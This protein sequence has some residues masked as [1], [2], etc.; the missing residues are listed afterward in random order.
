MAHPLEPFEKDKRP[1][2]RLCCQTDRGTPMPVGH[3]RT[4]SVSLLI[5]ATA[6][7]FL[8]APGG[9]LQAQSVSQGTLIPPVEA[10]FVQQGDFAAAL[11]FRLGLTD[12]R[13]RGEAEDR[14]ASLGIKPV[15]GW[16]SNDPVTPDILG[17]LEAAIGYAAD[18]NLL[19]L[20]PD[21]ALRTFVQ[22]VEESGMGITP[23]A[24]A[25]GYASNGAI[26]YPDQPYFTDYYVTEGPPII[27][28]YAPPPAYYYL[29][30]WV[31]YPFW[32]GATAFAGYYILKDRH[33]HSHHGGHASNRRYYG[34]GR[35]YQYQ[36]NPGRNVIG[37]REGYQGGRT[38]GRGPWTQ[39]VPRSMISRPGSSQESRISTSF[40]TAPPR[41]PQQSGRP[42]RQGKGGD[43]SRAPAVR[44]STGAET[45]LFS[46]GTVHLSPSAPG[47]VGIRQGIST[48]GGFRQPA[49][50][51]WSRGVGGPGF[52]GSG[53]AGFRR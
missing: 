37:P 27:T 19:P 31:P 9:L 28:Y 51:G 4:R 29:Y 47:S 36:A 48:G 16:V 24:G 15:G 30:S 17:Q 44:L 5:M 43:F 49:A 46:P 6:L 41:V 23:G 42:E 1:P 10:Q 3:P 14:L 21:E 25:A 53:H 52:S 38:G 50:R 7:I 35:N 18:A 40:R 8:W 2:Q 39:E 13:D 11:A 22:V 34:A 45:R 12:G 33:H 32:Y 20:T 26:T